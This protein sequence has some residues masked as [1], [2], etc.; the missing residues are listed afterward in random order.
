MEENFL[1][2]EKMIK[3]R[4]MEELMVKVAH[5]IGFLT[6]VKHDKTF[7]EETRLTA[8][9]VELALKEFLLNTE[10]FNENETMAYISENESEALKNHRNNRADL[11]AKGKWLAY[12]ML[13]DIL[14]FD[15]NKE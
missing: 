3:E 4:A 12:A 15:M 11:E 5:K 2:N 8:N 10:K 9:Y 14:I 1:Q 6:F 7:D 13:F